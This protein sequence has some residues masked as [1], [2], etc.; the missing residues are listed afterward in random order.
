MPAPTPIPALSRKS[1]PRP[2]S[3]SWPPL[4][5]LMATSR[6]APVVLVAVTLKSWPPKLRG[7]MS[8][9]W[10]SSAARKLASAPWPLAS[11]AEPTFAPAALSAAATLCD[12]SKEPPPPATATSAKKWS[13]PL[14][15]LDSATASPDDATTCPTFDCPPIN[16]PS[17]DPNTSPMSE[18]ER[19]GFGSGVTVVCQGVIAECASSTEYT[20][21]T[22]LS[23]ENSANSHGSVRPRC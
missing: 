1:P 7:S 10:P 6:S 17:A 11:S 16:C 12:R 23:F 13:S 14:P 2:V 18:R 20:K 4:R 22:N 21:S 5:F 3:T 9:A 8:R 15:R 19:R